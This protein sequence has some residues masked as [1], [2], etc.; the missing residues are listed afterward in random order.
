MKIFVFGSTISSSYGT[1]A[2]SYYRGIYKELHRRGHE[3][4]FAEP[5]AYGRQ[6]KRDAG[7]FSYVTSVVYHTADDTPTL[8][9]LAAGCDLV[10]KHSGV[11]VFDEMLEARG[12]DWRSSQTRVAFWDVG[13]P[14]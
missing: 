11:G 2:A 9:K 10:I 5:D 7:D 6:Q 13:A 3:I 12:F 14:A 8:L 1:G 4:T